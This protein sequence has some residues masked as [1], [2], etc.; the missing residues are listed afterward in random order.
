MTISVISLQ[1]ALMH[2]LSRCEFLVTAGIQPADLTFSVFEDGYSCWK[3]ILTV[4]L[5][6]TTVLLGPRMQ[7]ALGQVSLLAT[8]MNA[9]WRS[10]C[11][12]LQILPAHLSSVHWLSLF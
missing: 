9:G 12:A 1:Y 5:S 6:L 11:M 4:L 3:A 8:V 10:P 2:L 7:Q